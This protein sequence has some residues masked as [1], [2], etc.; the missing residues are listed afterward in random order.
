MHILNI[1]TPPSLQQTSTQYPAPATP[2]PTRRTRS[3][4]PE[5]RGGRG[6]RRP[7]SPKARAPQRKPSCV[8]RRR[9][10]ATNLS[11]LPTVSLAA[12]TP[13]HPTAIDPSGYILRNIL[14][15]TSIDAARAAQRAEAAIPA[16]DSATIVLPAGAGTVVY[17]NA[18]DVLHL[19]CCPSSSALGCEPLSELFRALWSPALASALHGARRVALDVSQIWPALAEAEDQQRLV[20]DIVFLVCTLQNA[21]EVL[22]LVDYSQPLGGGRGVAKTLGQGKDSELYW[23]M[24]THCGDS[25]ER[26]AER[27]READ[28]IWGNGMVWREVFD[29]EGL[30]WHERHPAFVFGQIFEEVVRLQQ[31]QWLGDGEKRPPPFQGVRVLVAE[32]ELGGVEASDFMDES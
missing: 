2:A 18:R 10:N 5:E 20:Q 6:G 31:G 22:Y 8:P 25:K 21:L 32:D 11:T 9:R 12:F 15:L 24:N 26:E 4:S 19:R 29:L 30:G 3:K 23:R 14:R 13:Q 16:A 7:T 27:A 17:D 1:H 28:V